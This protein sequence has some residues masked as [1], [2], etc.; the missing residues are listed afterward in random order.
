MAKDTQRELGCENGSTGACQ[1]PVL[2]WVMVTSAPT[3]M[4][5]WRDVKNL[6]EA[7]WHY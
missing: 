6:E 7:V 5:R 2:H 1:L 3:A 4:V